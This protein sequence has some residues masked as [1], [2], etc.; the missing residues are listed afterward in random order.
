MAILNPLI[1]LVALTYFHEAPI[2]LAILFIP[3]FQA[4]THMSEDKLM[5]SFKVRRS[6]SSE[7]L[8]PKN[9]VVLM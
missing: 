8:T 6:A 5:N 1:S 9:I 4:I 7:P 2:D 3:H